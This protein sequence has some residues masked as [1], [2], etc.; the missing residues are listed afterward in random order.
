MTGIRRNHAHGISLSSK[1]V[2]FFFFALT[3]ILANYILFDIGPSLWDFVV[4]NAVIVFFFGTIEGLFWYV[5]RGKWGY[6]K[7]EEPRGLNEL[8]TA[9]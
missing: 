6:P 8:D 7:D 5:A 1:S 9:E 2:Y 4:T 3:L